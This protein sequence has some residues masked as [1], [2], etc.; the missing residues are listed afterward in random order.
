MDVSV[1]D[2]MPQDGAPI[3]MAFGFLK[4]LGAIFGGAL[5]GGL[6][7][8][9]KPKAP[10]PPPTPPAPPAPD[11]SMEREQQLIDQ[12]DQDSAAHTSMLRRRRGRGM[13]QSPF[14]QLGGSGSKMLG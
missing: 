8:G 6:L 13:G 3:V 2:I 5:L 14:A 1:V 10:P 7:G 9:R 12:R 4:A 11:R